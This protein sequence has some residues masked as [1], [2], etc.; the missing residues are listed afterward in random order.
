MISSTRDK[1]FQQEKRIAEAM[2]GK[3]VIGSGSTPF[4]KGDVVV[5]SLLI[6]AKTRMEPSKSF[7][8]QKA[9]IEKAR[10]QAIATKKGDY[11]LAISFGDTKDYYLI[12]DTYMKDLYQSREALMAVIEALGGLE[13]A[14]VEDIDKTTVS[15]LKQLIRR[16]IG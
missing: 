4:L 7:T 8:V 15:G 2:G 3:Q 12:E 5:N 14:L 16:Y 11:A 9:W 1:S 10:E 13:D 6:E